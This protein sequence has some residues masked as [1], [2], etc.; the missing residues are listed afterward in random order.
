MSYLF[1][2]LFG[3]ILL[4]FAKPFGDVALPS[5]PA[6]SWRLPF[7]IPPALLLWEMSGSP[8]LIRSFSPLPT[9]VHLHQKVILPEPWWAL[10]LLPSTGACNL[11]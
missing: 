1:L 3:D 11:C 4:Y 10:P 2:P 9:S 5:P 7:S 8:S 6:T